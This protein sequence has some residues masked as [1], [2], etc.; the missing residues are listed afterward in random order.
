MDSRHANPLRDSASCYLIVHLY[1]THTCMLKCFMCFVEF[2][3]CMDFKVRLYSMFLE[4]LLYSKL[5]V[6]YFPHSSL[7]KCKW[8]NSLI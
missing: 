5:A 6:K 3:P 4:S 1:G 8:I 7:S 2:L